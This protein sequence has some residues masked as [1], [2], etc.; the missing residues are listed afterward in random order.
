MVYEVEMAARFRRLQQYETRAYGWRVCEIELDDGGV[1]V[2]GGAFC[3]AEDP[4]SMQ[5]GDGRFDLGRFQ[6]V[7]KPAM[8]G[9][10]MVEF[11][12]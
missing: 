12:W 7:F 4:D 5:L 10:S 1:L 6:R 3:W 11:L 2:R 9:K 8:I